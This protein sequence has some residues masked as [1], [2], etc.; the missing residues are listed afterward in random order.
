MSPIQTAFLPIAHIIL[1]YAHLRN[2]FTLNCRFYCLKCQIV[3]C[4][5]KDR[6]SHEYRSLESGNFLSSRAVSS[7]VL[8]AFGVLTSV[9]GMG[10]GGTL[11][12]SSP[13]IVFCF[14]LRIFKTAQVRSSPPARLLRLPFLNSLTTSRISFS[15]QDQALDLLVSPSSIRYRTSTDD[16]STLSSSRGLTCL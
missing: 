7:Q 9:F 2:R 16:L 11:Q 4:T 5:K 14:Y 15:S 1:L 6:H 8:S 12:L 13:E 3:T 10:T